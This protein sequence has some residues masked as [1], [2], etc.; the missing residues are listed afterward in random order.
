MMII[1][2]IECYMIWMMRLVINMMI[3]E[4]S[5]RTFLYAWF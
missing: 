5:K 1:D 4:C 2:D 3:I